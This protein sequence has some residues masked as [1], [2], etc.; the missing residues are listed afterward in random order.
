MIVKFQL[1]C[2]LVN[3]SGPEIEILLNQITNNC[4]M[5]DTAELTVSVDVDNCQENSIC[6]LHKNKTD[7]DTV[8]VNGTIV[9]DKFFKVI[10]IWVDDILL[11]DL[12][13][14]GQ[15]TM[16]YPAGFLKN[17][18]YIPDAVCKSDSLYFN[19]TLTY[20]LPSSFFNW[21]YEHHRQ[22]DLAYIQDHQDHEAEEKYLGYQ[23][24]SDVEQ[25][26]VQ[27]LESNGYHIT[28]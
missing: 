26:I 23:Q 13:C 28:R 4:I 14:Y 15:A 24:N 10:K 6:L 3:G 22:Q 16:I 18:D 12:F 19:G 20:H 2:G 1:L 9:E 17:I 5:C 25:E 7:Q 21:L 27:L 8:V 11:P